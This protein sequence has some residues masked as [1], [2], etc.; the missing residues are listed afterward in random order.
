MASTW[1]I[2][3]SA[4]APTTP[5]G[6]LRLNSNG[7]DAA[8]FFNVRAAGV[9]PV[10]AAGNSG[11]GTSTVSSPGN[12]PWVITAANESSGRRFSTSVT[13]ISG[14]GVTTP[15]NLVGDGITAGVGAA[16]VVHARDFGNALCGSG[17]AT[18]NTT[19]CTSSASNPF[20]PGSLAG[21]IVICDRGEYARIEKGC[22]VK[23]AGAVGMILA[24]VPGGD[25]NVVADG[26]F[27]PAVH[28]NAGRRHH[29]QEPGRGGACRRRPDHRGDF[30]GGDP[31]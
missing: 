30:V 2:S 18:N 28:L 20:A 6:S 19:T 1:S 23:L 14:H 27:L 16:Q 4:A 24:N 10:V 31:Q 9:V 7:D 17:T 12:A 25:A 3:R 13:G 26:H 29:D 22:N 21:K 11:P 5:W 15:F 8:A